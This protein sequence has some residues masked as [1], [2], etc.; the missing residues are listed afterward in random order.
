MNPL[1]TIL[2]SQESQ[3]GQTSSSVPKSP[4]QALTPSPKKALVRAMPAHNPGLEQHR[5]VARGV[6]ARARVR[7]CIGGDRTLRRSRPRKR[8][9]RAGA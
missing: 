4:L 8:H 7:Q 9:G 5:A 3:Y 1:A 6:R 2:Q